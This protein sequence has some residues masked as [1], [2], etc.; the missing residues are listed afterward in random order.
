MESGNLNFR[1]HH[2][3]E[4]YEAAMR[5]ARDQAV[6]EQGRKRF[7]AEQAALEKNLQLSKVVYHE[8]MTKAEIEAQKNKKLVSKH[9]DWFSGNDTVT[10]SIVSPEEELSRET[11]RIFRNIMIKNLEEIGEQNYNEFNKKISVLRNS[12]S[13]IIQVKMLPGSS[14]H[15]SCLFGQVAK[16]GDSSID[17]VRFFVTNAKAT[18][19]RRCGKRFLRIERED[20]VTT[21]FYGLAQKFDLRGKY[22]GLNSENGENGVM[23]ITSNKV[24]ALYYITS[25]STGISLDVLQD[26]TLP[27]SG[28]R[29]SF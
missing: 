13:K 12:L 27:N 29:P 6:A 17:V 20:V 16:K 24:D 2:T 21:R 23:F 18:I 9:S 15:G 28:S 8:S 14:T 3:E 4:F 1:S 5:Q 7:L 10:K 22:L 11:A 19:D 25:I 26:M